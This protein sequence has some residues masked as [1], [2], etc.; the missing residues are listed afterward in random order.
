MA[1]EAAA[2]KERPILFSSGMVRAILAGTKT[3]TRRV[4]KPQPTR[5]RV[6]DGEGWH[7]DATKDDHHIWHDREDQNIGPWSAWF[8]AMCQFG[9]VGERLWIRETFTTD[10][11]AFYPCYPIIYRADGTCDDYEIVKGKVYSPEQD[12]WYP[13]KWTP[14]IFMRRHQSRITL[15]IIGVRC[16]RIQDISVRDVIAE[17][18]PSLF[19]FRELWDQINGKGSWELNPWVWAISFKR[20]SP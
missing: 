13:F 5:G 2:V 14:S 18:L 12:H 8:H 4:L 7:W 6:C 10:H 11:A 15:E 19:R 16:E 3:Q 20:L 1:T 9:R 17:G